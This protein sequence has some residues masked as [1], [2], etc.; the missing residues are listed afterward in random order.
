MAS[1]QM[2]TPVMTSSTGSTGIMTT[3]VT[4]PNEGRVPSRLESA[5]IRGNLLDGKRPDQ[6]GQSYHVRHFITIDFFKFCEIVL[7]SPRFLTTGYPWFRATTLKVSNPNN[8]VEFQCLGKVAEVL[9]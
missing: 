3:N 4:G 6:V 5:T 7:F 9:F 2:S 1:A 8:K